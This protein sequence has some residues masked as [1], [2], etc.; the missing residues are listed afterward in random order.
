MF[1]LNSSMLKVATAAV[2]GMYLL[3]Q[4]G[5]F[6]GQQTLLQVRFRRRVVR[7]FP[8]QE[9]AVAVQLQFGT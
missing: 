2:V 5:D 6:S 8:Q 7:A 3:N 9:A 4:R 1:K